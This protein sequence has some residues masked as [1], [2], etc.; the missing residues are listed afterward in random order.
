MLKYNI[1]DIR[2]FVKNDIRFIDWGGY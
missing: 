2:E 1:N